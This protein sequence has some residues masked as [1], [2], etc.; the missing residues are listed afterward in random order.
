MQ[1]T[2]TEEELLSSLSTTIR[3]AM[4][5]CAQAW[6]PYIMIDNYRGTQLMWRIQQ[7]SYGRRLETLTLYPLSY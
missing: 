1:G 4:E 3:I 2:K 5:Y 6:Y 7:L